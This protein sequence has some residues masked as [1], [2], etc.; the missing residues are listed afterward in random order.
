MCR[1][2]CFFN[3]WMTCQ[4]EGEG[5]LEPLKSCEIMWDSSI[6]KAPFTDDFPIQTSIYRWI[7]PFKPPFTD[8]FPCIFR[9]LP[10]KK[11]VNDLGVTSRRSKL[12]GSI[13]CFGNLE[14]SFSRTR[15]LPCLDVIWCD[16]YQVYTFHMHYIYTIIHIHMYIHTY[17]HTYIYLYI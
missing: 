16:I 6:Y 13:R 1:G 10:M 8:D 4:S 14:P 3:L 15:W 9:G 5:W 2:V 12:E 17:T 11:H 7:F